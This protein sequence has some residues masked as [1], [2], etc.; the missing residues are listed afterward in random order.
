M[1]SFSSTLIA[2]TLAFAPLVARASPVLGEVQHEAAAENEERVA[3]A[4]VYSSCKNNKQVALTF[5]DGPWVYAYV[6]LYSLSLV[7]DSLSNN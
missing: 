5:D 7:S 6:L 3:L 2:L 1:K 4:T